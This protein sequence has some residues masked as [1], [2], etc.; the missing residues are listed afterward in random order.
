MSQPVEST[1]NC[2]SLSDCAIE[3]DN[4]YFFGSNKNIANFLGDRQEDLLAKFLYNMT[5]MS[6]TEPNSDNTGVVKQIKDAYDLKGVLSETIG[7]ALSGYREG[8]DWVLRKYGRVEKPELRIGTHTGMLEGVNGFTET[9]DGTKL[10]A[11]Q[12]DELKKLRGITNLSRITEDYGDDVPVKPTLTIRQLYESFGV[13]ETVHWLQ[14]QG[15]GNLSALPPFKKR[16]QPMSGS[17]ITYL[18]QPH[19]FE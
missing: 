15:I 16:I 4:S 17:G 11:L 18:T 6:D 14:D 8:R 2:F 1:K 13:E 9:A 19:E 12:V 3:K 7:E 5:V 10:I